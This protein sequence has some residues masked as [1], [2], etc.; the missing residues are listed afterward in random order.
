MMRNILSVSALLLGIVMSAPA[1][2][3]MGEDE[4]VLDDVKYADTVVV[5]WISNYKVITP[6]GRKRGYIWDYARFE[7]RVDEVLKGQ[8]DQTLTVTWDNSTFGEPDE[9]P[10]GPYLIALRNPDS[11]TIPPL[12]GP[13]A[14]IFPRPEPDAPTLLQA[15][16][17]SPFMFEST[18]KKAVA[19]R[20]IL[21]T[22]QR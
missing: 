6:E 10:P 17:A 20:K 8:A 5:G 7:V 11:N 4:I 3:C 14:T 21:R 9:I 12:R 19:L 1:K 13:S 16:C 15:P 22:A 18:S 2:A